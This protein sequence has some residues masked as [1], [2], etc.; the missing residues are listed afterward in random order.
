MRLIRLKLKTEVTDYLRT[1]C[2]QHKINDLP[3]LQDL[4]SIAALKGKGL[5]T[6]ARMVKLE[7]AYAK[8]LKINKLS[9]RVALRQRRQFLNTVAANPG[10]LVMTRGANKRHP[11][12]ITERMLDLYLSLHRKLRQARCVTCQYLSQCDFGK[13]YGKSVSSVTVVLD[14]DYAKKM[15]PD[16]PDRPTMDELSRLLSAQEELKKL[17]ED[18]NQMALMSGNNPEISEFARGLEDEFKKVEGFQ[19]GQPQDSATSADT[20]P[21]S[22]TDEWEDTDAEEI[23]LRNDSAPFAESDHMT[24]TFST[25]VVKIDMGMVDKIQVHQFALFEMA[26]KLASKLSKAHSGKLKPTEELMKKNKTEVIESLDDVRKVRSV[27]HARSD[28]EFTAKLVTK[29]LTKR[30]S[31][32]E[33]GKK[34]LIFVVLDVSSSMS[35]VV[36]SGKPLWSVVSRALLAA[37]FSLA[38]T[39]LVKSEQGIMFVRYFDGCV[40]PLMEARTD[41]E[42]DMLEL[43]LSRCAFNGGST[44]IPGALD[45]AVGDIN[46]AKNELRQAEILLIT[47]CGCSI[48]PSWV[49]DFR[50]K[51]GKIVLNVLDV[52]SNSDRW[53]LA[54]GAVLRGLADNYYKADG[55]AATLDKLVTLVGNTHKKGGAK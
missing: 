18:P 16:C 39:R 31:L 6:A 46:A 17:A 3:L 32:K 54:A 4:Y 22:V 12:E 51:L 30:T 37:S 1:L 19:Q 2:A 40:G 49:A 15:H 38:I 14:P 5:P 13:Q 33:E 11:R 27:E 52:A 43:T 24:V 47:D 35:S 20:L 8:L 26:K 34:H 45:A 29:S 48:S 42:F 55:A 28:E 41:P 9:V 23:G 36:A 7:E 25:P 53:E 44:N 21:S 50:T 10:F